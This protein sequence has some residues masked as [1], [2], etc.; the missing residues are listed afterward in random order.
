MILEFFYSFR[1]QQKLFSVV[2]NKGLH[3]LH[4]INFMVRNVVDTIIS[5]S[6]IGIVVVV[7]IIPAMQGGGLL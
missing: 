7:I 1:I 4:K 2:S 6:R 5:I 3:S